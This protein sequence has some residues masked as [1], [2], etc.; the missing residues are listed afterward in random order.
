[1]EFC[2]DFFK[3]NNYSN[4]CDCLNIQTI[5]FFR[6]VVGHRLHSLKDEHAG[7]FDYLMMKVQLKVLLCDSM[8]QLHQLQKHRDKQTTQWTVS[9]LCAFLYAIITPNRREERTTVQIDR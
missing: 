2:I 1:M 3:L 6:P 7:S 4:N 8:W 9:I 5:D